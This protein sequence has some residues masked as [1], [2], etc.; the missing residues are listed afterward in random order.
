MIECILYEWH[1]IKDLG[2]HTWLIVID[3]LC[4]SL[5]SSDNCGS[6]CVESAIAVFEFAIISYV[7]SLAHRLT[8]GLNQHLGGIASS[9]VKLQSFYE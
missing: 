9:R 4:E 5:W 3:F 7:E 2:P 1:S 8:G 6:D